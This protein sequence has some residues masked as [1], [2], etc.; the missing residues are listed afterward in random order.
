MQNEFFYPEFFV[1]A[2]VRI[3][4]RAE[5]GTKAVHSEN[6]NYRDKVYCL[7]RTSKPVRRIYR[8]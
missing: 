2:Q 6:S 8:Y 4:T 5:T 7:P 3:A 1:I